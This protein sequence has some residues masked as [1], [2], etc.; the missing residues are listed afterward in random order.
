MFVYHGRTGPLRIISYHLLTYYSSPLTAHLPITSH[1]YIHYYP[2]LLTYYYSPVST[3]YYYSPIT[4][5]PLLL[6]YYYSPA[7]TSDF[8][9]DYP[10][11]YPDHRKHYLRVDPSTSSDRYVSHTLICLR[12]MGTL[13]WEAT[14]SKLFAFLLKRVYQRERN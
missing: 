12:R 3:Y 6:T 4:T 5:Q 10:F 14:Q 1:L 13:S 11:I 7:T 8:L 2:L 9:S